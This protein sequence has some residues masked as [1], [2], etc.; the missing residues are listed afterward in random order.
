MT[1]CCAM[2]LTALLLPV[3]SRARGMSWRVGGMRPSAGHSSSNGGKM[4]PKRPRGYDSNGSGSNRATDRSRDHDGSNTNPKFQG[5]Q[6]GSPSFRRNNSQGW[7]IPASSSLREKPLGGSR[8][9]RRGQPQQQQRR[10]A[11]AQGSDSSNWDDSSYEGDEWDG[12]RVYQYPARPSKASYRDEL[13]GEPLYGVAPILTALKAGVRT[14]HVLLLQ[15]GLTPAARKDTRA[16]Q[17]IQQLAAERGAAVRWV[18]KH[19]LNML[20]GNRCVAAGMT[21]QPGAGYNQD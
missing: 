10:S 3:H 12:S 5:Q 2:L 17:E 15:E 13:F 6:H 8:N 18:S 20:S 21:S 9:S 4:A 14:P 11:A 1:T 16:L 7:Q 19:E